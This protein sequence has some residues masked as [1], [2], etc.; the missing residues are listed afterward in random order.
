[1]NDKDCGNCALW[2]TCI[3]SEMIDDNDIPC[4]EDQRHVDYENGE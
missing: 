4:P 2:F 1:M 3:A